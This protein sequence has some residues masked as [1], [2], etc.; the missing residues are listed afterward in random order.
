[1]DK[2]SQKVTKDPKCVEAG[3]KGRKNFMNKLKEDNLN[4][5]KKV[6]EIL[7]IQAM[8]LPPL[9][10]MQAMKLP[11]LLTMQAMKLPAL[12]SVFVYFFTYNTFQ[13]K[14]L[15]NDCLAAQHE[16]KQPPKRRHML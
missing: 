1:M 4:D 5:A 12:P 2:T 7:P 10:T 3:R 9:L 15:I 13:P 8:N 11:A 6:A 14:K 16:Q